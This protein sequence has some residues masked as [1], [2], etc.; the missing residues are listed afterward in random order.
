[1]DEHL[2]AGQDALLDVRQVAKYLGVSVIT[3][4]RW[5]QEGTLPC[6]KVGRSVRI[7]RS[8][9]ENFLKQGERSTTLDGQLRAFLQ[10]PDNVLGIVQREEFSSK[11][12][13]AFLRMGEARGGVLVKFYGEHT[14]VAS[15][16]ELR[17]VLE[18]EGFEVSRV[19]KEGRFYLVPEDN[20]PAGRLSSLWLFL[21][22]RGSE[23]E[24]RTLWASFNWVGGVDL[25]EALRYQEELTQFA[26]EQ[27]AVVLT[28][29]LETDAEAWEPSIQRR[30]Q[31]LHTSTVWLSEDGLLTSRLTPL[32]K[33]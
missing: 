31:N 11:L 3:I 20:A 29:M 16:E 32:D 17:A 26:N 5:C 28:T 8:A 2:G 1:M 30:V 9:L 6:L 27:Q 25:D 12:D 22:E 18:G 24:G 4:Y 15:E 19:E 21:S 23:Q 13:A 33:T 7:R 14:S 10:V